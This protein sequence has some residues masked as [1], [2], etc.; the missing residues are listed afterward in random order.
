MLS[1]LVTR[2][3]HAVK[4][5]RALL[6]T[7]GSP[8]G[9]LV[10]QWAKIMVLPQFVLAPFT[11]L[12]G[13]VEGPLIFLARFLAMHV[14]YELDGRI[15]FTRALGLCHLLT[16]GPLFLWFSWNFQ[17]I[18]TG[19][20]VF[21]PLFVV[22][23]GIIGLCLFMDS[24]DLILHVAGRPYPCYVRDYHRLGVIRIDDARVEQPVNWRTMLLW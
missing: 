14:V 1:P 6:E 9:R 10:A 2:I 3:I 11:L 17:E 21:G 13:R 5:H 22:E 12:F 23:Y 16:F 20:G 4:E 15:P 7:P 8:T 18:Y 19:W 24:R